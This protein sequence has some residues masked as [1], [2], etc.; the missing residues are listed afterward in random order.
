MGPL[1]RQ[2]VGLASIPRGQAEM[3]A[4]E[5]NLPVR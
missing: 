2:M 1:S 5:K 4:S 3:S